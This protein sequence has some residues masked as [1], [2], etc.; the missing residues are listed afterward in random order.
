MTK[1][2]EALA[3]SRYFT[4]PEVAKL[5]GY[6]I[7][8]IRFFLS[9]KQIKGVKQNRRWYISAKEIKRFTND[10]KGRKYS[11]RTEEN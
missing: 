2:L 6:K 11:A 3:D 9:S 5:T 10:Y 4:I 7:R 1:D 8:T